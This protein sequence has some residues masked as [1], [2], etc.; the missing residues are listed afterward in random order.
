MLLIKY[1]NSPLQSIEL[2]YISLG[3]ETYYF[4]AVVKWNCTYK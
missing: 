2:F 4:E 1:L 3:L